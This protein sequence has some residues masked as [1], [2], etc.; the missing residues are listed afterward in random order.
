MEEHLHV[1]VSLCRGRSN[2]F[3]VEKCIL[4]AEPVTKWP[5]W[6]LNDSH[7]DSFMSLF[8]AIFFNASMIPFPP[9]PDVD[10]WDFGFF[11]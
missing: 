6:E 9:H 4:T 7:G 8:I 3:L 5:S 11:F 2:L 10:H 1:Y